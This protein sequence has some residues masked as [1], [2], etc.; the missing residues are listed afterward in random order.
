MDEPEQEPKLTKAEQKALADQ[1]AQ[2]EAAARTQV[3]ATLNALDTIVLESMIERPTKERPLPKAIPITKQLEF[4]ADLL[5]LHKNY[6]EMVR[7]QLQGLRKMPSR[8]KPTRTETGWSV[9]YSA[10]ITNP[11]PI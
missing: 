4:R 5:D 7:H 9:I 10:T 11:K 3:E 2:E 6:M 8:S 1:Q